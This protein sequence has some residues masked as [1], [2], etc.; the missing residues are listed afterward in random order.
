MVSAETSLCNNADALFY[1]FKSQFREK[2]PVLPV[3]KFLFLVLARNTIMVQHLI[4][5]FSLHYLSSGRLLT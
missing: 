2:N 1:S 4:I 5:H 3:E